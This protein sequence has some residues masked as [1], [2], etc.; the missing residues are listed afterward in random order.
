[1]FTGTLE[2]ISENCNLT[3]ATLKGF[4]TPSYKE[5]VAKKKKTRYTSTLVP[6]DFGSKKVCT[7]CGVEKSLHEFYYREYRM[8]YDS[9]C[10]QCRLARR[11]NS[12]EQKLLNN[13]AKEQEPK[14]YD[15]KKCNQCRFLEISKFQYKDKTRSAY[16]SKY[17]RLLEFV[18][19]KGKIKRPLYCVED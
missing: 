7:E 2:E 11:R 9:F 3:V 5:K 1:M 18:K 4:L 14:Y 10:S 15:N 12:K 19:D 16:C 8:G 17:N 6:V 13:K